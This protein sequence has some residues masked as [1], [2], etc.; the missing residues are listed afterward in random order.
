MAPTYRFTIRAET[1]MGD[2]IAMV[3]NLPS[4]GGW[5]P[6]KAIKLGTSGKD[7]PLWAADVDLK[8]DDD[9]RVE[10]KYL[11]VDSGGG[12][13]WEGGSTNRWVPLEVRRRAVSDSRR[14][15]SSGEDLK[16]ITVDDGAFGYVQLYPCSTIGKDPYHWEG[17][18]DGVVENSAPP[19]RSGKL[20]VVCGSSVALG[21]CAWLRRGWACLLGRRLR[22]AYGHQLVNVAVSGANAGETVERFP[23]FVAPLKPAFVI[24]GLAPGNEGLSFGPLEKKEEYLRAYMA[25]IRKLVDLARG[26]GA[27]PVVAGVYGNDNYG[28]EHYEVLKRA[29]SFTFSLG[30]PVLEWLSA[31]DDGGGKWKQG[32]S[33][34]NSHPN[35]EGHR[36]MA[37]AVDI[38]C[39]APEAWT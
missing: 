13:T 38:S 12:V 16:G 17:A 5:D 3:G 6:S 32:I 37:E 14:D 9:V 11:R 2:S 33:F 35:T 31:V 23:H 28:P 26:I 24:I 15:C 4:L 1:S 25:G 8:V 30:V 34:D 20:V 21:R 18:A 22:E 10:Y 29:Q 19:T 7:Y 27:K 36:L 39:F